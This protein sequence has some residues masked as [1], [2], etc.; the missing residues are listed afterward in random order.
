[1]SYLK[2]N[3]VKLFYQL[4]G[5]Q[6]SKNTLVFLNGVM[7]STGSWENQ[8]RFFE[9]M[10]FKI[11]LHDFRGQLM[12]DKPEGEYSFKQHADD[13]IALMDELKIDK[14]HLI[15]TSYGGEVAM[16]T[17]VL[18][19]ER[20]NTASVIDSVS[21]LDELLVQAINLWKILAEQG[22]V[23]KFYRGMIPSI[24]GNAFV[25][26]NK[27]NLE[28]KALEMKSLSKEYLSGQ[29]SLYNTFLNDVDMTD[30]LDR[31]N[32][33][34]LVVCGQEDSLKRPKFSKII[35]DKVKNSEYALI[36]DCGHVTIYEK[37]DVLNSLLL[38][39][40]LKNL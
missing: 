8:Y 28:K 34:L 38:G 23:E 24:Y 14:A 6:E 36:P 11:L 35:A 22:D 2:V 4:K 3:G 7:A 25:E 13:L 9:K 20:V 1:M 29:I 12:S 21:E 10:D 37:P 5:N 26:Q 32:A 31:I 30:E 40:I 33:P 15:G 39:F 17:A 16:K 18:Y 19:P 27:E